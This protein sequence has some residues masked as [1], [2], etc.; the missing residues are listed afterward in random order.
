MKLVTL[1]SIAEKRDIRR[2]VAAARAVTA[3]IHPHVHALPRGHA[4]RGIAAE[5]V[6]LMRSGIRVW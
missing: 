1:R 4:L 5:K 6:R 3:A 2:A